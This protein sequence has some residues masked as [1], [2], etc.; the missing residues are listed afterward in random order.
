MATTTISGLIFT[1]KADA[2]IARAKARNHPLSDDGFRNV[3]AFIDSCL[4]TVAAIEK[5]P[6]EKLEQYRFRLEQ[7]V[8]RL[9]ALDTS[10]IMAL[11][12]AEKVAGPARDATWLHQ[13]FDAIPNTLSTPFSTW[14]VPTTSQAARPN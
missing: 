9:R 8:E 12:E 6:K 3:D 4:T 13:F 11:H 5:Q 2:N 14:I 10:I 1:A 7:V